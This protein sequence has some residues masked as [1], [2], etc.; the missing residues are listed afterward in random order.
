MLVN[1]GVYEFE[2]YDLQ[3]IGVIKAR[4]RVKLSSGFVKKFK[5]VVGSAASIMV[6]YDNTIYFNVARYFD[7][8]VIHNTI[9]GAAINKILKE[10]T[11]KKEYLVVLNEE[12]VNFSEIEKEV[13]KVKRAREL[14]EEIAKERRRLE[15][16]KVVQDYY[17]G[18][19]ILING[20]RYDTG[21]Y[22]IEDLEKILER[23]RKI[24]VNELLRSTIEKQRKKIE[25]LEQKIRDLRAENAELRE[26]LEA[27]EDSEDDEDC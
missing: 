2:T 10:G 11:P 21:A 26:K 12:D 27:R 23:L 15:D 14:I 3:G 17:V 9:R 18:G 22:S 1:D 19:I 7:E 4:V 6:S 25:E 20:E 24:D 16:A 5:E 13:E 8:K